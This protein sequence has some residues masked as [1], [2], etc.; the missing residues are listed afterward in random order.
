MQERTLK[1]N[2]AEF[3]RKLMHAPC[4]Y[5]VSSREVHRHI[6]WGPIDIEEFRDMSGFQLEDCNY[7]NTK[8]AQLKRYYL[9]QQSIDRAIEAFEK[10]LAKKSKNSVTFSL[11]GDEKKGWTANDFCMTAGV[12]A[13]SHPYWDITFLYRTTEVIQK[14]RGDLIFFNK[15]ILPMFD[16][17][18]AEPDQVTFYFPSLVV[19]PMYTCYW[20][21]AVGEWELELYMIKQNNGKFHHSSVRSFEYLLSERVIKYKSAAKIRKWLDRHKKLKRYLEDYVKRQ[22]V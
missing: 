3:C 7:T 8:I 20:L 9:N 22:N 14:F 18:Q 19:H 17:F 5:K 6:E 21:N 2:W 13:Y 15:V 4:D 16:H 10:R 1:T 12:L 11:H